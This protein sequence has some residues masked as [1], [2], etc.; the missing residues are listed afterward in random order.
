MQTLSVLAAV[1]SWETGGE[2]NFSLQCRGIVRL[3]DIPQTAD[4][5]GPNNLPNFASEVLPLSCLGNNV[6]AGVEYF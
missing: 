6:T 2:E 5:A 4:P 3:I 1:P